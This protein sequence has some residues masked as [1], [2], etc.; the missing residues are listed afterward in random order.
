MQLLISMSVARRADPC[1]VQFIPLLYRN[2][3]VSTSAT[4]IGNR[5]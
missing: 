1:V 3:V 4:L 5:G 2:Q